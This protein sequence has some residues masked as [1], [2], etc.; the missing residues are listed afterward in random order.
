[1]TDRQ[2]TS[3]KTKETQADSAGTQE[4]SV[5]GW[6]SD[7]DVDPRGLNDTVVRMPKISA[8][9]PPPSLPTPPSVHSEADAP[10][11]DLSLIHI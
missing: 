4:W 3:G 5:D 1:M 6:Q 2:G 10:V 9:G 8:D 11:S 7:S